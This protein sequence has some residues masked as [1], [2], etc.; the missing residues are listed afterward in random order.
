MAPNASCARSCGSRGAAASAPDPGSS[1]P[2]DKSRPPANLSWA[3]P[4][5]HRLLEEK[6]DSAGVPGGIFGLS[7]FL[8]GGRMETPPGSA[9]LPV[10][11]WCPWFCAAASRTSHSKNGSRGL[12]LTL[13]A[14]PKVPRTDIARLGY[15]GAG[16]SPFILGA[17]NQAFWEGGC[18][19][20][21]PGR[22]HSISNSRFAP[23]RAVLPVSREQNMFLQEQFRAPALLFGFSKTNLGSER[24]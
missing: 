17:R 10:L 18:A 14:F 11:L 24:T 21:T 20:F 16:G 15:H 3:S 6:R 9:L 22:A 23:R 7:P 19:V 12:M 4:A 8:K 13:R 2:L 5:K 1:R